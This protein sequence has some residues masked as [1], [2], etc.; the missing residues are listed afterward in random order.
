MKNIRFWFLATSLTVV[1]TCLMFAESA[2]EGN[3][4]NKKR[5]GLMAVKNS[6]RPNRTKFP[7][8]AEENRRKSKRTGGYSNS[9]LTFYTWKATFPRRKCRLS[10]NIYEIGENWSP[11][12]GEPFGT[13]Y[14]IECSCEPNS[15]FPR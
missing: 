8:K 3:F 7:L 15:Q 10:K 13:M 11:D 12:L 4:A 1:T 9:V 5:P 6:R 14:C 2:P